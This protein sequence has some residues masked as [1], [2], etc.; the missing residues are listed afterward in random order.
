MGYAGGG[1][2]QTWIFQGN[3]DY[4]DVISYLRDRVEISWTMRQKANMVK[5]GDEVY[6]WKAMGRKKAGAGIF[7]KAIVASLPITRT[8]E[9]A[10]QYW[11]TDDWSKPGLGVKL[12]IQEKRLNN[13]FISRDYLLTHPILNT[14][15]ILKVGTQTNYLIHDEQQR[16]ELNDLWNANYSSY[17]SEVDEAESFPEGAKVY[18]VHRVAE[19]NQHLIKKA[20]LAAVQRDGELKCVICS[21]SFIETY[22]EVG[23]DYIEAHHTTPLSEIE[24]TY[25]ATVADIALVCSNCHKMLHRRRPWL[26]MD[27]L[28]SLV[29]K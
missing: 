21:F 24:G 25:S 20:K 15:H 10:K 1:N 7:A 16:I 4:F 9:D 11:H 17:P 23:R 26:S 5:V 22:G 18:R 8:D 14:L 13:G 12:T 3:P 27:E 29:R 6:I 28:H 19:R 2:M